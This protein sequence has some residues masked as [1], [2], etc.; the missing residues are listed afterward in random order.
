VATP[1][2][3]SLQAS[4]ENLELKL[5][6]KKVAIAK[7]MV[8]GMVRNAHLK[9]TGPAGTPPHW[10]G[11]FTLPFAAG[12]ERFTDPQSTAGIAP[13]GADLASRSRPSCSPIGE[14]FAAFTSYHRR[15]P[16]TLGPRLCDG[17][18]PL[19]LRFQTT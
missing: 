18:K 17:R 6:R 7:L 5:V 10:P 4:L 14:P 8:D 9:L 19:T 12:R 16:W 3:V 15:S 1:V 11:V 2:G 13:V